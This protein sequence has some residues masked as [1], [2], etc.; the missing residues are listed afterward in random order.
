MNTE[1]KELFGVDLLGWQIEEV[2]L[3]GIF[4]PQKQKKDSFS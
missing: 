3:W 2:G 4:L 1:K